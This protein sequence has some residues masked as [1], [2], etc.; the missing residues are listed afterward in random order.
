MKKAKK[1]AKNDRRGKLVFTGFSMGLADLVPG[2][3]GGTI[4]LLYGVYEEL[5]KSIKIVTG[6]VPRLLLRG[7]FKAALRA[8]PLG[9]L[10]PLFMGILLAIFSLVRIISYLLEAHPVL[11]WSLFFGLI[12]GSAYVVSRR[13]AAW[14]GSRV[15]LLAAGFFITYFIVGLPALGGSEGEAAIFAT[16]MIAIS[17]MILPGIS[18]SLIMV[19]LGQYETVIN[20]VSRLDVLLMGVFALGALAGLA[21]FSRA[22]SWLLKKYHA[23]TLVFLV[24]VMLGSLRRVWPWQTGDG[25]ASFHPYLPSANWSLLVAVGLF[26]VGYSLIIFLEKRGIAKDQDEFT[27]R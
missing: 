15:L 24:G 27:T 13:V 23:A 16:G 12:L 7:K 4:A 18:G 14:N 9:F 19:L 5:L 8:V 3:S 1:P 17:A 22:L 20:A 25:Y 11:V 6:D 2:V 21:V 10:L 26:L